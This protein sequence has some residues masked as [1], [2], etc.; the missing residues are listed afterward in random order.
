MHPLLTKLR[1]S[2][3][4]HDCCELTIILLL[5]LCCCQHDALVALVWHFWIQ[6]NAFMI[7][8]S[9]LT[10]V[11]TS[12]LICQ[13]RICVWGVQTLSLQCSIQ[14]DVMLATVV[15]A[16]DCMCCMLVFRCYWAEYF[17]SIDVR[18]AFWSATEETDRINQREVRTWYHTIK[19][20]SLS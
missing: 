17:D 13:G 9:R 2:K 12:K 10:T 8:L 18:V 1:T 7:V 3:L 4:L 14:Y 6:C 15:M 19:T 5:A 20:Q 11:G 16:P